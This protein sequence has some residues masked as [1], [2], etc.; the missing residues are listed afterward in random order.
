MAKFFVLVLTMLAAYLMISS[1]EATKKKGA[2]MSMH[3]GMMMMKGPKKG[4][5]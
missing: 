5:M 2:E 1:V 3:Y 4:D